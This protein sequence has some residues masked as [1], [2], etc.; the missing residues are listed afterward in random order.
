MQ[1]SFIWRLQT[2]SHVPYT[3]QTRADGSF[4]AVVGGS[5]H[6]VVGVE[7]LYS[8]K[9]ILHMKVVLLI[10]NGDF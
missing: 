3:L 6:V 7:E 4:H 5:F 1:S 10:S 2:S 8:L 9:L